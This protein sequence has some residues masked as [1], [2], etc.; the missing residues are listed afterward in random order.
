ML[1]KSFKCMYNIYMYIYIYLYIIICASYLYMF[2][3]PKSLI[4]WNHIRYIP[5]CFRKAK[6]SKLKRISTRPK[7]NLSHAVGSK[8]FPNNPNMC[9]KTQTKQNVVHSQ[10]PNFMRRSW[11][12]FSSH[13]KRFGFLHGVHHLSYMWRQNNMCPRY[14]MQVQY[15]QC[16]KIRTCVSKAYKYHISHHICFSL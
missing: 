13:L 3:Q 9:R 8:N 4:Y 10:N 6:I 2:E 5:N 11:Y 15:V 12:T 7:H 1:S 14:T 16:M